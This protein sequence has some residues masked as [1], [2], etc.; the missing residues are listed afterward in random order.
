MLFKSSGEIHRLHTGADL[1]L[2]STSNWGAQPVLAQTAALN[3][4]HQLGLYEV[5]EIHTVGREGVTGNRREI[6]RKG[7]NT[8]LVFDQV[9]RTAQRHNI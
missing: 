9:Q 8:V 6:K 5:K 2:I 3:P 4:D 1:R 7:N